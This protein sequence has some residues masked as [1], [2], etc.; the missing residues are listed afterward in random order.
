MPAPEGPQERMRAKVGSVERVAGRRREA[1]PAGP[2][3]ERRELLVS[4]V[5][6]DRGEA[7]ARQEPA[8]LS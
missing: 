4:V 6:R 8:A 2:G 1:V 3:P 5:L 7:A